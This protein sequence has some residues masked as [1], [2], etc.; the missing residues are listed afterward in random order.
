MRKD[1]PWR[2]END[3]PAVVSESLRGVAQQTKRL[4]PIPDGCANNGLLP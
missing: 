4:A 2:S 3:S 1:Y